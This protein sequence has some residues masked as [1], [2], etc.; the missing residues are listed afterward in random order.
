[1]NNDLLVN[2][3]NGVGGILTAIVFTPTTVDLA[4][5]D[6][7]T[8]ELV[9]NAFV[10]PNPVGV[11]E[12][13]SA[14]QDISRVVGS[15][16]TRAALTDDITLRY[17]FGYDTYAMETAQFIP[18]GAQLA[19]LGRASSYVRDKSLIN[20]DVAGNIE[21]GLGPAV[22]MTTSVGLNHTYTREENLVAS[23]T[24]LS[25]LTE[26]VRGATQSASES[27][28]ETTTLGVFGQQQLAFDQRLFLTGAL[29]WDASSTFGEDERWQLYP[30]VSG[31]WLVSD[32]DFWGGLD[33]FDELRLRAALGYA[34]NQPPR[35]YAYA[36]FS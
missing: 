3:E 16:L 15:F 5:R 33:W 19:P 22:N 4:E 6:P 17:S 14:P 10:F 35:N 23:A 36:R 13:W 21:W 29:R 24:D 34:G 8:G 18:R 9:N 25:P 2:G 11:I 30:K 28:V 7:E 1:S 20:N 31:S 12:D 27:M 32:E 26:L